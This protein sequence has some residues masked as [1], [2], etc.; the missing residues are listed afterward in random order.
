MA[1]N[2]NILSIPLNGT[3]TEIPALNVTDPFE[4]YVLTSTI[5]VTATGN[6]AIVP[7]GT[8]QQGTTFIFK[9]KSSL[10]ITTTTK[11]FYIF[12]QVITKK[13]LTY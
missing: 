1:I 8:P 13:P 9:Y 10:E 6:Y 4:K 11:T 12:Q 2:L 5:T 7:T 3:G